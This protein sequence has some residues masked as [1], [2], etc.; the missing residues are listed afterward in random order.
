M[1]KANISAF[2]QRYI[3]RFFSSS[4]RD[5]YLIF[6]FLMHFNLLFLAVVYKL[7][8]SGLSYAHVH[9]HRCQIF[10]VTFIAKTV[11]SLIH[12]LTT[13][14]KFSWIKVLYLLLWSMY[15]FLAD[16]IVFSLL[17]L[18]SFWTHSA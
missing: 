17:K 4:F 8:R 2:E 1:W 10:P 18:C 9:V 11:F 12:I 13:S 5:K 7:L 6:N 14:L 16:E 15:L 3:T